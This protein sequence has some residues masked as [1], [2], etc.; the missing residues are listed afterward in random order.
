MQESKNIS[1]LEQTLL[2]FFDAIAGSSTEPSNDLF[3]NGILSLFERRQAEGVL[4]FELDNTST[5]NA[6]QKLVNNVA[7]HPMLRSPLIYLL[8]ELICNIQQHAQTDLGYAFVEYD[9]LT[10][11]I[12]IIIA[13]YG[14]SIYGSYAANQ[15]YADRLGNSDADALNMAKNGFSVKNLPETENRGYG[16]SS[17]M[18]MVA[19]GLR[20]EFAVLSGSA[21]LIHMTGN[22]KILALPNEIDYKGTIIMVRI[23]ANVPESFNM[24]DYIS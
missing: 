4:T 14:I 1:S 13:D 2:H 9:K 21:L 10:D 16:I 22:S 18:K 7:K 8:D 5:A 11:S 20:G 12:E 3:L 15:K 6:I 19:D 24:Y 23:P 17:N